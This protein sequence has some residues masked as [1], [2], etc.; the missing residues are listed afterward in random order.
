[1][2][3]R[4]DAGP[5]LI[6]KDSGGGPDYA[7]LRALRRAPCGAVATPDRFGTSWPACPTWATP[8]GPP[9]CA[10]TSRLTWAGCLRVSA[11]RCSPPSAG[12]ELRLPS[13]N[14]TGRATGLP[15]DP[16]L[17][18]PVHLIQRSPAAISADVVHGRHKAWEGH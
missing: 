7:F 12:A 11:P 2:N 6:G 5:F 3:V 14:V 17:R 1:M 4:L 15:V 9:S 8:D 18:T 16:S 10:T 13:V